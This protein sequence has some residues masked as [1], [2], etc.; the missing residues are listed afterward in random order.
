MTPLGTL[1]AKVEGQFVAVAVNST[2]A[3]ATGSCLSPCT[4]SIFVYYN[5]TLRTD[6]SEPATFRFALGYLA[7]LFSLFVCFVVEARGLTI[8]PCSATP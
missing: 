6:Y 3:P 2:V 4:P 5:S 7:V 8:E 1:Y